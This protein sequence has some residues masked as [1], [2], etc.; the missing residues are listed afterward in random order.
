MKGAGT[1]CLGISG[2]S[3][4][5]GVQGQFSP[6]ARAGTV[7]LLKAGVKKPQMIETALF[8]DI[9]DL[10]PRI[11][12]QGHCFQEAYFHSQGGYGQA[13]MLM[14]QTIQ[15]PATATESHRQFIHRKLQ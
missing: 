7:S 12:Q 3:R 13:K 10:F 5:V 14:K 9:D 8:G 1:P 4:I 15:V 11:S 2:R 6:L